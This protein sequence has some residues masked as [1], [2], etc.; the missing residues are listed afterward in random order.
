MSYIRGH[1]QDEEAI[2]HTTTVHWI[3]YARALFWSV[4]AIFTAYFA[5]QA[6]EPNYARVALQFI[7]YLSVSVA[8]VKWLK[9]LILRKTTELAITN[10]RIIVK[11][12]FI[13]RTTFEMNRSKVES[14]F[15]DQGIL[16]RALNFGTIRFKGVGASVESFPNINR[17]IEF[18]GHVTAG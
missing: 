15:V 8:F 9:A 14:V 3:V 11:T 12:G 5:F 4:L 16:G 1:L 6:P 10:R 18:R 2:I 7:V 17:P 13:R